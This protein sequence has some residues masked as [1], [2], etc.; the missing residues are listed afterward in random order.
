[1]K[2][3]VIG[4]CFYEAFKWAK[5]LDMS[6]GALKRRLQVGWNVNKALT[7]PLAKWSKYHA[8]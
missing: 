5:R 1:M 3:K 2:L 4:R 6:Y 7:T 8:S